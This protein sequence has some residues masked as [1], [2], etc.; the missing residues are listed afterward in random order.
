MN[1]RLNVKHGKAHFFQ[2]LT[3]DCF[4]TLDVLNKKKGIMAPGSISKLLISTSQLGWRN[5]DP[6]ITTSNLN[7]AKEN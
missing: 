4:G 5:S 3:V 1:G 7:N 6:E 2:K